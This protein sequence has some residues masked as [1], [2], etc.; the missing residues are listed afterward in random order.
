MIWYY[1]AEIGLKSKQIPKNLQS[2]LE[3]QNLFPPKSEPVKVKSL[4]LPLAN[5]EI[6]E[7]YLIKSS[8]EKLS[9]ELCK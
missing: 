1:V 2:I 5:L 3:Q 6:Y 8:L 7:D 4:L 9:K